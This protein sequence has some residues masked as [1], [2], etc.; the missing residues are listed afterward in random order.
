VS[1]E[2]YVGIP[3]ASLASEPGAFDGCYGLVVMVYRE[4]FGIEIAAPSGARSSAEELEAERT[5]LQVAE[6][7]DWRT[8]AR[9]GRSG[10]GLVWSEPPRLFD[11]LYARIVGHPHV[12]LVA[13][14]DGMTMLH[15]YIPAGYGASE[16]AL[17]TASSHVVK[18]DRP[19]WSRSLVAAYRHPSFR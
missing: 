3:Y 12:G 6:T 17:H 7:Q 5:L 13:S 16:D 14:E 19:A 2:R 15:A 8:V 10:V 11:V 1:V 4:L 18:L 9:P